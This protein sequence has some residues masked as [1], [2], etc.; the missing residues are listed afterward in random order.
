MG[1]RLLGCEIWRCLRWAGSKLA[2][3]AEEVRVIDNA[4][5]AW[6]G[7]RTPRAARRIGVAAG[8]GHGEGTTAWHMQGFFWQI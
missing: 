6:G 1:R 3:C 7:M 5:H 8:T 2:G 4:R